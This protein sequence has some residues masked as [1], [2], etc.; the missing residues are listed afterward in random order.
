MGIKSST[1]DLDESFEVILYAFPPAN[2]NHD[3]KMETIH[4]CY[5][6][7]K[8]VENPPDLM[9]YSH[10]PSFP[11]DNQTKKCIYVFLSSFALVRSMSIQIEEQRL[12]PPLDGIRYYLV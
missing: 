10:F 11:F 9:K 2:R 7:E 1:M 6:Q 8:R 4:R 5:G 12:S 3:L